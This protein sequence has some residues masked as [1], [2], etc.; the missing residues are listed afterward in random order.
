[1]TRCAGIFKSSAV[2]RQVSGLRLSDCRLYD[3]RQ[4]GRGGVPV[5]GAFPLIFHCYRREATGHYW[6]DRRD[7]AAARHSMMGSSDKRQ[8]IFRAIYEAEA[9]KV[10]ML[11]GFR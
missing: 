3:C 6:I 11:N 9:G 8:S 2:A 7:F 4:P 1:M 10:D 5:K